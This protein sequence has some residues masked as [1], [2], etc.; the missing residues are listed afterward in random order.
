MTAPAAAPPSSSPHA[1]QDLSAH[2][3]FDAGPGASARVGLI[4]LATD[5]VSEVALAGM[6]EPDDTVGLF[7]TRLRNANPTTVENLTAHGPEIAAAAERLLPGERLDVMVYGC[8]SGSIVLGQD[9]VAGQIHTVRPGLPVTTP[10]TAVVTALRALGIERPA[11]V[12]PYIT[13]VHRVVHDFLSNQ[14]FTIAQSGVFGLADD[15]DM[16]RVTPPSIED[17]VMAMDLADADGVFISCTALRA[18]DAI[19]PLEARLGL[20]VVTS[21]QALLWHALRLAGDGRRPE[22]LG[23]LWQV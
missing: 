5:L 23:R 1:A 19:A 4:L 12:T 3:R 2:V 8:T 14:G 9:Q 11:L 16:A 18:A 21:H 17:A 7:A 13:D 22:R 15:G 20:P 6:L 10:G